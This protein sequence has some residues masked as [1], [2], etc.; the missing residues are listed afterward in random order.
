MKGYLGG[1]ARGGRSK[2][3]TRPKRSGG[4]K[5]RRR[6][7]PLNEFP[8]DGEEGLETIEGDLS[9]NV[10]NLTELKKEPV[11]EL[12]EMANSMGLDNA[13]RLRK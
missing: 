5:S 4:N 7:P 2:T 3:S 8:D 12:V 11:S 13:A 10:M 6:K 1:S 9:E